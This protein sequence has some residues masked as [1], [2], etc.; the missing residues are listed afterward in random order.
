MFVPLNSRLGVLYNVSLVASTSQTLGV[1][2]R[3][4]VCALSRPPRDSSGFSLTYVGK[5]EAWKIAAPSSRCPREKSQITAR[6]K[7][8]GALFLWRDISV[9]DQ[10]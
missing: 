4:S 10:W 9:L 6:G 3:I 2:R 8:H 7:N 5:V 1:K